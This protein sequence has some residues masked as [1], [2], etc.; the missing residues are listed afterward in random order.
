MIPP[1]IGIC[2]FSFRNSCW[3]LQHAVGLDNTTLAALPACLRKTTMAAESNPALY[4]IVMNALSEPPFE[5]AGNGLLHQ[6]HSRSSISELRAWLFPKRKNA[7]PLSKPKAWWQAQPVLY[8]LGVPKKSETIAA[9]RARLEAAV[10]GGGCDKPPSD[11][12]VEKEARLNQAFLHA[13]AKRRRERLLESGGTEEEAMAMENPRLFLQQKFLNVTSSSEGDGSKGGDNAHV[14]MLKRLDNG[15][16]A[17]V[18]NAASSL[19]LHTVSTDAPGGGYGKRWLLVGRDRAAVWS[20]KHK[21]DAQTEALRE[22]ERAAK[23]RKL[24]EE[25]AQYVLGKSNAAFRVSKYAAE[26]GSSGGKVP[27]DDD[28]YA[29]VKGKW[30]ITCE[31]ID[32]QWPGSQPLSLYVYQ[33]NDRL[34]DDEHDNG[35]SSSQGS[36]DDQDEYS[37]ELNSDDDG[38]RRTGPGRLMGKFD[39]RVV[40]GLMKFSKESFYTSSTENKKRKMEEEEKLSFRWRGV[41]DGTG[42]V[43]YDPYGDQKGWVKFHGPASAKLS[44]S[45]SWQGKMAF[46][47]LKLS[48]KVPAKIRND[49]WSDYDGAAYERARVGRWH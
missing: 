29:N 1:Q 7:A 15:D 13:N 33:E 21:I 19:G 24:E 23:R 22:Q 41:E 8:G 31:E 9:L 32:K 20:E 47:G 14:C 48:D 38:D 34:D 16:R 12:L 28:P 11:Q 18:H 5:C 39:F 6:G 43:L 25:H 35:D 49:D 4:P 37:S 44:G 10:L 17:A 45:I 26:E 3:L 46:S 42:E 27:K 40:E 30:H 2:T 36:D